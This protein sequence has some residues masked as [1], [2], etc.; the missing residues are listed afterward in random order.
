MAQQSGDERYVDYATSGGSL[1]YGPIRS[2][3]VNPTQFGGWIE[4]DGVAQQEDAAALASTRFQ[5]DYNISQQ[6]EGG[7][8]CAQA[9]TWRGDCQQNQSQRGTLASPM[10]ERNF[11]YGGVERY[12][13]QN[14]SASVP[15]E[16]QL[17]I[18]FVQPKDETLR[19]MQRFLVTAL[20]ARRARNPEAFAAELATMRDTR[21]PVFKT[22][23]AQAQTMMYVPTEGPSDYTFNFH[24]GVAD[25]RPA[26]FRG[27]PV[28]PTG[29][30]MATEFPQ[31]GGAPAAPTL[32][33]IP[34]PAS[35]D[36]G[37]D[38][39]A[40]AG[41][42]FMGAA[43]AAGAEGGRAG[44]KVKKTGRGASVTTEVTMAS[45]YRGNPAAGARRNAR[46]VPGV[47]DVA[48][49][50][51]QWDD[52]QGSDMQYVAQDWRVPSS[53]SYDGDA[54]V[55]VRDSD[56]IDV[57]P[58]TTAALSVFATAA[59]T[60]V[61]VAAVFD[62]IATGR[63]SDVRTSVLLQMTQ[64][65]EDITGAR[66]RDAELAGPLARDQTMLLM[67]RLRLALERRDAFFGMSARVRAR[68]ARP[69]AAP[70]SAM[71]DSYMQR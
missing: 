15:P 17:V 28:G 69:S 9:L 21:L 25:T 55:G 30:A 19:L 18:D 7:N 66:R 27:V 57:S 49:D 43:V 42:G 10:V 8:R 64:Y 51:A 11:V 40:T 68:P 71:L 59:N 44:V 61:D 48:A 13:E 2:D 14:P 4:S 46:F 6:G 29:V 62:M 39:P 35:D 32:E 63:A 38:L 20:K 37:Y 33:Q 65:I 70:L 56:L 36:Y 53:H 3:R 47:R 50:S 24:K 58:A 31:A 12:S 5:V 54:R 41:S 67:D 16:Q 60:P 1:V 26:S 23:I 22:A 52:V 45:A 34:L